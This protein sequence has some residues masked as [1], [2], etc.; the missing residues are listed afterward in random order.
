MDIEF[1]LKRYC[2]CQIAELYN[3]ARPHQALGYETPDHVY[4][5]GA[6]GGALIVDKFD[7]EGQERKSSSTGQRRASAEVEM[8]A[9]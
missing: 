5:I 8:D 1:L 4:R 9:A 3:G 2:G 6:G 7:G